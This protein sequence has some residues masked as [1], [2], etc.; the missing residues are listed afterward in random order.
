MVAQMLSLLNKNFKAQIIQTFKELSGG[1]KIPWAREV[2]AAVKYYY[3]TAFQPEWQNETL[4]KN[5]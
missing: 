1:G 4:L 5:K 3:T 2:V